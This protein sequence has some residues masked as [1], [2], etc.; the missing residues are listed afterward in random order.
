MAARRPDS[1]SLIAEGGGAPRTTDPLELIDLWN[2][3]P[4]LNERVR[5]A[6]R[7]YAPNTQL[8]LRADWRRWRAT[9]EPARSVFRA[10]IDDVIAFALACSPVAEVDERGVA[11]MQVGGV[12]EF[13]PT[14]PVSMRNIWISLDMESA[15]TRRHIAF[16]YAIE[17]TAVL[18][19]YSHETGTLG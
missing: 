13:R 9:Q 7:S 4:E 6:L 3:L 14:V 16:S 19:G 2:E 12:C 17:S 10:A 11:Q 5:D 1:S 15:T 8:G 18:E